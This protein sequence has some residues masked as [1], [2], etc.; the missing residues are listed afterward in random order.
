MSEAPG[1]GQASAPG[2]EATARAPWPRPVF[3]GLWVWAAAVGVL[4]LCRFVLGP[5]IPFLAANLKAV[6]VLVFLYLP[7]W[8][9]GR[10]GERL[11]DYGLRFDRWKSDLLWAGG[12]LLVVYPPFILLFWGFLEVLP[13]LGDPWAS[14]LAPYGDLSTLRPAFRLPDDFLLLA[15]THLIVVA[16]PEELFYRGFLWARLAEG[17]GSGEGEGSDLRGL[18]LLGVVV[19]P[20]FLLTALLFAL[21]HLTEPYPWRLAVFFPALLFGWLRLRSGGLLAPIL[22][23]GFSNLFMATLEASFLGG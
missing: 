11:R 23:H 12:T 20:A 22:V 21:G 17:L 18:R 3:T 1:E 4:L 5:L 8:L 9:M 10:R 7:V 13:L 6:A 14:W 2:A 16:F 15:G 19:G